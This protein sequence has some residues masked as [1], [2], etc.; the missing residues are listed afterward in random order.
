MILP[1]GGREAL[2]IAFAVEG[3]RPYAV[4]VGVGGVN[5]LTGRP[6]AAGLRREPQ[7]YLVCPDQPWLDGVLT[8]PGA[9]RQF[10][11]VTS[12][13]GHAVDEQLG[14]TATPGLHLRVHALRAGVDIAEPPERRPAHRMAELGIGTGGR[15]RQHV[16]RDRYG[17]TSWEARD[18]GTVHLV[19]PEIYEE[20]TATAAP[21]APIS[22]QDYTDAGLPWFELESDAEYLSTVTEQLASLR[23]VREIDHDQDRIP[24]DPSVD[25]PPD[26]IRSVRPDRDAP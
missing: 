19:L 5:A 17:P 26:Q 23:S 3:S 6:W 4:Q 22:A 8:A 9:V 25:I 10:T 1:I 15:I 7:D 18:A 14:A 21:T 12:G 16:Y 13:T 11:A 2:W 20:L 24:G